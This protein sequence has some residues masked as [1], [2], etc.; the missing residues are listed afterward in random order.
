M[1]RAISIP[2]LLV[3]AAVNVWAQTGQSQGQGQ[4]PQQPARDTPAQPSTPGP[5]GRISGRVVAADTGRPVKRARVFLNA[6][7]LPGGRGMLTDDSGA[8]EVTDLPAGRYTLNVSKSGF[9]SLSYGQRRPLQAGTPLQLL[10]G[11]QLKSVDFS[12]PRGGVISGRIVD[13]DGE[14][15]PGA[16]VRVMRYQY[17]QG[18][19][20]LMQAGTGQTDDRG[21]YR[22][23]GLMPG[24][25]Y[26]NALTRIPGFGG[27]MGPA[28]RGGPGPG[29]GPPAGGRA[30]GPGARGGG[31]AIAALAGVNVAQ[32]FGSGGGDDQEQMNYA[33][34][35]YPGV[36]AVEQAR[37]VTV[38]VSQEV[39][40]ISFGLQLVRTSRISGHVTNP[41]GTAVTAGNV[42]LMPSGSGRGG[43]IGQNYGGRIQWDG[44]FTVANVPPGRYVLRAR[45]SDNDTPQ[46]AAQPI[47]VDGSDVEG[48]AVMLSAGA[49]LT[50]TVI[51]TPGQTPA[52]DLTQVR[53][54]APST[55]LSAFG[56]QPN[57]RV[58]KEGR[59][60]LSG[61]PAGTHLIRSNG[62]LR[63]W[64][65]KSVSAGDRDVTDT[66]VDVRSGQTLSNVTIVFTDKI[67][68]IS[69]TITTTMGVPMPDYTVLA[70]PTDHSLWRS[71][72]RQIA[73]T[74]PDQTG[75][76][77]LRGLPPGE[78]YITTV[79]PAEQGEWFEPAY[80]DDHRAGASRLTLGDGDVKTQD[81]KIA[82]R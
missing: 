11:Q 18:D 23:W 10:D 27:P 69:G 26:V 22:V 29:G 55:D 81:F 37:P 49:T 68:E 42:N 5:S 24:D 6:A 71:Q 60:T 50:G 17:Q 43:Q 70:F 39:L 46:F 9:V 21:Q 80:L 38:G 28:G 45:G 53:I 58:D 7:E 36:T 82:L 25:Y 31:A 57:A 12:L 41:D 64:T 8:Y 75:K 34:T 56:P 73:T 66:P 15:V 72:A 51:F 16:M 4:R 35:Y 76:Y 30:G 61:V 13:E 59:F 62:N 2:A 20:Q 33:P 79:D 65:L 77:R 78:Y 67:N 40:E 1:M 74:R 47:S 52:P 63:G 19:R 3:A 54:T 48:L 32:L 44:A 14:A